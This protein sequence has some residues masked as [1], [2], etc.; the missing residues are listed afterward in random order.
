MSAVITSGAT[1]PTGRTV[2]TAG[3]TRGASSAGAGSAARAGTGATSREEAAAGSACTTAVTG[4]QAAASGP[5][6]RRRAAGTGPGAGEA[7]SAPRATSCIVAF[8]REALGEAITAEAGPVGGTAPP[9]SLRTTT[10]PAGRGGEGMVTVAASEAEGG[11][12]VVEAVTPASAS[13]AP[14]GTPPRSG[15]RTGITVLAI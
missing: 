8:T 5:V 14:A 10:G 9:L 11:G 1:G 7:R 13:Q 6:G 2:I 4:S 3:A 15:T 12:A